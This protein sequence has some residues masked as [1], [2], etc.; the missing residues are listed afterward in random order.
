MTPRDDEFSEVDRGDGAGEAADAPRRADATN[1]AGAD[2]LPAPTT[3]ALGSGTRP[4]PATAAGSAPD[5]RGANSDTPVAEDAGATAGPAGLP[6]PLPAGRAVGRYVLGEV[7]GEGGMGTVYRAR[8]P[9]LG[10]D[11]A[12]KV[13]ASRPGKSRD[14]LLAEARAMAKLEH[15]NVLP[16]Y[17]VGATDDGIYFVMPLVAGGTLHDWIHA[18][19]RPWR[20]VLTRFLAAGRGLAAAHAAGLVHR[21][22]KPRNVLLDGDDV[23]VADFGLTA[24][25]DGAA[26]AADSGGPT[27]GSAGLPSTIAGTPA[28]MAP[29]QARGE[30]VD[31]RADQYSFCISLWEGLHGQRPTEADT[32]TS[33][34]RSSTM[35]PAA[36]G[37]A[38]A[39]DWLRIALVRGFA[40][41]PG[42]RW[43]SLAGLLDHLD[44][45]RKRT[46]RLVLLLGLGISLLAVTALLV[47]SSGR[48]DARPC[49]AAATSVHAAWNDE[50][51]A[52]IAANAT[53]LAPSLVAESM[54]RLTPVL[55]KYAASVRS[56]RVEACEETHVHRRQPPDLLDRR[57]TCLDRRVVELRQLAEHLST[58]KEATA[59]TNSL[60]AAHSLPSVADCGDVEALQR[61][62]PMP[63][64]PAAR[65]QIEHVYARLASIRAQGLSPQPKQQLEQAL[66]ALADARATGHAPL[67]ALA[68]HVVSVVEAEGSTD[69]ARLRELA[70]VAAEAG[71]DRLGAR[72]WID[73]IHRLSIRKGR[74]ADAAALAPVAEAAVAR[75]GADPSLR[76]HLHH[77]LASHAMASEDADRALSHLAQAESFADEPTNRATIVQLRARVELTRAGPQAALPIVDQAVAAYEEAHGPRHPLT[78]RV[79]EF[80]TQLHTMLGDFE[81]AEAGARRALADLEA[82]H[83]PDSLTLTG[84]LRVLVYIATQRGQ[85]VAARSLAE[86]AVTI[87]ERS[88]EAIGLAAAL[89]SLAQV[90][91]PLDGFTAARPHFERAL[92]TLEQSV[93]REHGMYL[94]IE[95]ELAAKL[96]DTGDCS[97]AQPHLE[98]TISSYEA[99]GG[100]QAA[101]PLVLRARCEIGAGRTD[102]GIAVFE[103]VIQVCREHRCE[104]N[105]SL[106]AMAELGQL[107]YESRRDRKRGAT[108]V[109]EALAG[110]Q[111]RGMTNHARAASD[112]LAAQ[113]LRPPG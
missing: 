6:A 22:F 75:A 85:H 48:S 68:L 54:S 72:A 31:A 45:R 89:G 73:M 98:H 95:S 7:L 21:D 34:A 18:R 56:M 13:V 30:A 97:A 3:T 62:Q 25:A 51:R 71:D 12:L 108:L 100:G 16:I 60:Q 8:D 70:A 1:L 9:E 11:V 44:T 82:V 37:R 109:R 59:I 5:P 106:S 113:R 36:A 64:S 58:S 24:A 94:S 102:E 61:V 74:L 110:F 92:A 42:D 76:F 112:W 52:A 96:V 87:Q 2:T 80:R 32:R 93:G 107:L 40:A 63:S 105:T 10:R 19:P 27:E 83:G 41:A 90:V 101:M 104:P 47:L 53:R 38:G 84:A 99:R 23:L 29:E 81:A 66:A 28:Y 103:R 65:A 78:A 33:T 46:M 69:E 79:V 88:G 14:R 20:E 67:I 39:P 43:P 91:A 35:Q 17:D 55:E 4:A 86:R 49:S 57:Q 50:V 77:T 26:P 15:P 111:Q